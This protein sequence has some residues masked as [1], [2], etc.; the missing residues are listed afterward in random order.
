MNWRL[1]VIA[2]FS[3]VLTCYGNGQ[4][5]P[6]IVVTNTPSS[7]IEVIPLHTGPQGTMPEELLQFLDRLPRG[8][9][10]LRNRTDI[11]VTAVVAQWTFTTRS[12]LIKHRQIQCDGYMLAPVQTIVSSN[13]AALVT[14]GACT[15][16][17]MFSRIDGPAIGSPLASS[18]NA[19]VLASQ[20]EFESIAITVD[21]IIFEDG[22]IWG[23]DQQ[24]YY[25]K[26]FA[27]HVAAQ[28]FVHEVSEAV[29]RGEDVR[30]RARK[31]REQTATSNDR[32]SALKGHYAALL[33]HS[34]NPEATLRQLQSREPLPE[35]HHI[36]E[37]GQ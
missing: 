11:R 13:D 22:S 19:A 23:P 26:I 27:R 36:Q 25:N 29:A 20:S 4:M 31:I 9:F 35:F 32:A 37:I 24:Q 3:A 28:S 1:L 5:R 14:P 18:I 15:S 16:R 34:P 21:S 7:K 6:T 12:G 10:L 33:E 2:V 30:V 8:S 17:A